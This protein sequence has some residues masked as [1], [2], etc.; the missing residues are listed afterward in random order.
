M[1]H[2]RATNALRMRAVRA[3]ESPEEKA[4]RN[5]ANAAHMRARRRAARL[6]VVASRRIGSPFV[7]SWPMVRPLPHLLPIGRTDEA[8]L[9]SGI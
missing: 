4:R 7:A 9:Y 3:A 8:A 2:D 6:V 5:A 1:T